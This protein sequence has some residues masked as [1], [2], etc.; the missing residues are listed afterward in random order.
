MILI[1]S[2]ALVMTAAAGGW[3]AGC[4]MA[5]GDDPDTEPM[6]TSST[7]QAVIGDALGGIT[8]ADFTTA[9]GAFN[10][11]ETVDDGL[12]PIFNERACGNC[13]NQGSSGGAGVQIERRFGRFDSNGL[14]NSLAN[15]GGSLRQL[16]ALPPFT[17]ANGRSCTVPLEHEPADAT[18]HN[19][20]RLTTPL[21]GLGLVDS[22]PDSVFDNV[23][24]NEPASVRGTVNR[25]KV[26]LPDPHDASQSINSTRVGRFGW[27]AGI[28]N[29]VQFSADAYLNEMGITTQHCF[30]GVSVLT[31]ATE[32]K[33]NGVAQPAGCDDR[34]PGGPGIP[35]GTDDGVGSCAGGK[36]EIQDDVEL[37]TDFMTF[38]A[39]PPQDG[40]I[41]TATAIRAAQ[42]FLN[43][44]CAG[45]HNPGPYTTPAAPANGVPGNLQFFPFSDFALH[46]MGVLGDR[47]GNDGD[48]AARTRMMRT[49]PL[50]G[51][52]FR[53]HY[54][55]D[56]SETDLT[57]AI[58]R[59][60]GQAAASVTSFNALSTSDRAA[61]LRGLNAI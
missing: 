32:S 11:V 28:A 19:V 36:T 41:D 8:A 45:C 3:L 20:G 46:D 6:V 9:R 35:A 29:L 43:I 15:E 34:G 22:L 54:L 25:V 30:K 7:Q 1:R 18:I 57:H 33:P 10:T 38:L 37:F 40:T 23:V 27:K 24:A 5:P 55:H 59:H 51:L 58:R 31:F 48:T 49:A 2:R 12:G 53:N 17:G 47:I 13:H 39:P 16:M 60:A 14:F 26:L 56:G 42:V 50:W 52:R 21:F 44:G 4:A 61:L